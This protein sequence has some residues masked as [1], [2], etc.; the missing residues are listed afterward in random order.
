MQGN[1]LREDNSYSQSHSF[2][3]NTYVSPKP[4][5]ASHDIYLW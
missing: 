3:R 5:R 2:S 4:N 1:R